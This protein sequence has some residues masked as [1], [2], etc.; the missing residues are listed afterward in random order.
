MPGAVAVVDW[1]RVGGLMSDEYRHVLSHAERPVTVIL[2][3]DPGFG[4]HRTADDLGVTAV[5]DKPIGRGE[6]LAARV[7]A[8]SSRLVEAGR[9]AR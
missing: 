8:A 5:V 4:P 9:R 7:A 2:L 1:Q 3:V 6:P